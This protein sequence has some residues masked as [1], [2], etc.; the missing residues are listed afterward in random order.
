MTIPALVPMEKP[1]LILEELISLLLPYAK[2]IQEKNAD[3]L[4]LYNNDQLLVALVTEGEVNIY[5]RSNMMLLTNA[6]APF[7]FGLQ[8][9]L[10]QYT[11]F[12]LQPLKNA[13]ISV[14]PR[15]KALKIIIKHHAFPQTLAYQT[16]LNEYQASR[17]NLLIHRTSFHIVC[18][19]IEELARLKPEE[20]VKISISKYVLDRSNLARSGVM[21]IIAT[22]REEGFIKVEN[23]KLIQLIKNLPMQTNASEQGIITNK[24]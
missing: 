7:I 12:K 6:K 4:H 3:S 10:F 11:L 16:Y 24:A 19:L 20:R 23:G 8:G 13:K 2:P 15:E 17:N 14:L 21:K 22:L 1:L 9:S 18:G 5:H